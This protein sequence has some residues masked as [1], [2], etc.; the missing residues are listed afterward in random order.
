MT[1]TIDDLCEK[2]GIT[3]AI[4][5]EDY[6][7][8]KKFA[9]PYGLQGKW[10][11]RKALPS[12]KAVAPI[13]CERLQGIETAIELG[14][15]TGFRVL[16]YAINNPHTKF[17]A[18]DSDRNATNILKERVK[19][20]HLRNIRVQTMDMYTIS[21]KYAAVIAIDCFGG[22][23]HSQSMA[24]KG[25]NYMRLAR[26]VDTSQSESLFCTASYGSLNDATRNFVGKIL[27]EVGLPRLEVVPFE[28]VQRDGTPYN[29]NMLFGKL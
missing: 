3:Q 25:V 12:T 7:E 6:P 9:A 23:G 29:G 8:F 13:V 2:L 10:F 14:A 27:R 21:D 24:E 20:L 4:P 18:V 28:F 26:L 11:D 22:Q 17:L 1:T 15:G 16:Y 19:K 5:E